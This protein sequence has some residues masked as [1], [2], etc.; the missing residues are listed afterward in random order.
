MRWVKNNTKLK[1][2]YVLKFL[3]TKTSRQSPATAQDI[4]D[5]LNERGIAS[6]RKSIYRDVRTF[7]EFGINILKTG[8]AFY[9]QPSK[10]DILHEIANGL[11]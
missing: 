2:L 8:R 11:T 9:Y 4:I 10:E 5:H 7:N 6:E 3:V 1:S